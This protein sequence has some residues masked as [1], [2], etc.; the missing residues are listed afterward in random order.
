[1]QIVR[2]EKQKKIIYCQKIQVQ[3]KDMNG[4]QQRVSESSESN[5][6]STTSSPDPTINF[7]SSTSSSNLNIQLDHYQDLPDHD[8]ADHV[9]DQADDDNSPK[10]RGIL[11]KSDSKINLND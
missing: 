6:S 9:S 2:K 7:V 5:T 1:L 11:R 8:H 3:V 4:R 10:W